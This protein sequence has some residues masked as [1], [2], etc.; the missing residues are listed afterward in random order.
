MRPK[1]HATNSHPSNSNNNINNNKKKKKKKKKKKTRMHQIV[2]PPL[3]VCCAF[4]FHFIFFSPKNPPSRSYTAI[5]SHLVAAVDD[6]APLGRR[7]VDA[8]LDDRKRVDDPQVAF[9]KEPVPL[10]AADGQESEPRLG[11]LL[12]RGPR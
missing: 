12:E 1:F 4:S 2:F 8:G 5:H 3:L 6:P 9:L 10:G 11:L 7:A